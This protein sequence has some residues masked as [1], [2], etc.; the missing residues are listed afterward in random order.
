MYVAEHVFAEPLK[1]HCPH[2]EIPSRD[3]SSL[4]TT[5]SEGGTSPS[6]SSPASFAQH[7]DKVGWG[8]G[9]GCLGSLRLSAWI[10]WMWPARHAPL[11]TGL[12]ACHP[13]SVH[14]CTLFHHSGIFGH[15]GGRVGGHADSL[16]GQRRD[17]CPCA[18][19]S[20][21]VMEPR[22]P[23]AHEALMRAHPP[24]DRTSPPP[25]MVACCRHLPFLQ[26]LH[27]DQSVHGSPMRLGHVDCPCLP[28]LPPHLTSRGFFG[29]SRRT[30]PTTTPA[31]RAPPALFKGPP[32][33]SSTLVPAWRPLDTPQIPPQNGLH[34]L[35]RWRK[36]PPSH[37]ILCN[38][39]GTRWL[40]NGT[41]KPLVPRR[42][43][44]YK[45]VRSG[46]SKGLGA[47]ASQQDLSQP[48]GSSA[49]RLGGET[50]PAPQPRPESFSHSATGTPAPPTPA[51]GSPPLA[52]PLLPLG[53]P[54]SL[55]ATLCKRGDAPPPARAVSLQ[56]AALA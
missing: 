24:H 29:E 37:P 21:G 48:A 39:C 38:A 43:L 5:Q 17:S 53:L 2:L 23:G 3:V 4:A 49:A 11:C 50:E 28:P 25:D 33:A 35:L 47:S 46:S 13:H 52:L 40:R 44:R 9:Q 45:A 7:H 19:V 51:T 34:L 55:L 42:G 54:A 20:P 27:R 12:K 22:Q 41:L 31:K 30:S 16:L 36:G 32:P 8:S 6:V 26:C 15:A 1:A 10:W 18:R 56:H 14:P